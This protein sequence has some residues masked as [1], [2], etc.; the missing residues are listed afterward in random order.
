[1]KKV[2]LF[3][4]P[5]LV[6][7]TG[8]IVYIPFEMDFYTLNIIREAREK[9]LSEHPG[10]DLQFYEFTGGVRAE[11]GSEYNQYSRGAKKIT[12]LVWWEFVFA[13]NDGSTA[14]ITRENGE[15]STSQIVPEP[16]LEDL[17]YNPEY[18]RIDLYDA[19]EILKIYIWG[20]TTPLDLFDFVVFRQPVAFETTEPYYIFTVAPGEYVFVGAITGGIRHESDND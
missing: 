20:D 14:V 3:V 16:W 9:I 12:D 19:I 13:A 7:L 2:I 10:Q 18:L 11:D 1:M 17:V 6:L 15:W 5:L 4:F 8:C